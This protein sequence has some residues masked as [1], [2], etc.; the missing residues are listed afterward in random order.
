MLVQVL[1]IKSHREKL[2]YMYNKT[3][4]SELIFMI[5]T[6]RLYYNYMMFYFLCKYLLGYKYIIF[7]T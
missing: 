5:E 7:L 1:T 4:L 6:F 3:K 2:Y